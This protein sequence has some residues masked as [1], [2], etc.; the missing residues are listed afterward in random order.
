MPKVLIWS[1]VSGAILF[2]LVIYVVGESFRASHKKAKE[3]I[4][5]KESP[6]RKRTPAVSNPPGDSL[7]MTETAATESA[8]SPAAPVETPAA[9]PVTPPVPAVT[10]IESNEPKKVAVLPA[11]PSQPA[12]PKPESPILTKPEPAKPE[13]EVAALP[14]GSAS[15]YVAPSIFDDD[16]SENGDNIPK[17]VRSKVD[18]LYGPQAVPAMIEFLKHPHA[19]VRERAV[20]SLNYQDTVAPDAQDALLKLMQDRVS[21]I[22][23]T[24]ATA[25]KKHTVKHAPVIEILGAVVVKDPVREVRIAAASTL[26]DFAAADADSAQAVAAVLIPAFQTAREDDMSYL[27]P[28]IGALGDAAAP[29]LPLL[30]KLLKNED[31]APQAAMALAELGQLEPLIPLIENT[32][33]NAYSIKTQI[34]EGFGRQKKLT[35]PMLEVLKTL[36]TDDEEYVRRG[37]ISALR[38]CEPKLAE[39]VP[40]LEKAQSD[41]SSSVREAAAEAFA[42]YEI[43]PDSKVRGLLKQMLTAKPGAWERNTISSSI[44][45]MKG[46]GLNSL[47]A[48]IAEPQLSPEMLEAAIETLAIEYWDSESKDVNNIEQMKALLKDAERPLAVRTACAIVLSNFDIQLPQSEPTLVEAVGSE[49]MSMNLR[50]R[51][52]GKVERSNSKIL[53]LFTDQAIKLE[54]PLPDDAAKELREARNRFH[55]TILGILANNPS[56]DEKKDFKPVLPRFLTAIEK[57]DP[58]VKSTAL[59]YLR[60]VGIGSPE[61]VEAARSMLKHEADGVRRSALSALGG[62]HEHA[63]A[64]I[65]DIRAALKDEDNY[66]AYTAAEALGEFGSAAIEAVPDLLAIMTS[67][68]KNRNSAVPMALAKIA[69]TDAAVQKAMVALLEQKK[70]PDGL[71]AALHQMGTR[72]PG[73]V[74]L[75]LK[76]LPDAERG[77]GQLIVAIL[78]RQEADAKPAL[79]AMLKYAAEADSWNQAANIN[80]ICEMREHAIDA[81]PEIV[82]F[83]GSEDE[84]VQSAAIRGLQLM[85][86]VARGAI[87]DLNKLAAASKSQSVKYAIREAIKRLSA[88]PDDVDGPLIAALTD[89]RSAEAA[90][91]ALPKNRIEALKALAR[92]SANADENIRYRAWGILTLLTKQKSTRQ[93]LMALLDGDDMRSAALATVLLNRLPAGGN[94]AELVQQL[95]PWL[96]NEMTRWNTAR[97]ISQLGE[98]AAKPLAVELTN[99][100]FPENGEHILG[101]LPYRFARKLAVPLRELRGSERPEVSQRAT[102]LLALVAPQ[103]PG[104]LPELLTIL[105]GPDAKL[106]AMAIE[107][108]ARLAHADIDISAAIP[109]LMKV[110]VANPAA[111]LDRTPEESSGAYSAV[112]VV[113]TAGVPVEQLPVLRQMLRT[114]LEAGA[115]AEEP[116]VFNSYGANAIQ[117]LVKLGP[118]AVDALP[119]IKGM[120]L[121]TGDRGYT[122]ALVDLGEPAIVMLSEIVKDKTVSVA[123]RAEFTRVIGRLQD[124]FASA[125][126]TLVDLLR[127][128]ELVVRMAAALSLCQ[129]EGHLEQALPVLKEA[130]KSDDENISSR[131]VQELDQLGDIAAAALVPD[132][133]DLAGRSKDWRQ[134]QVAYVLFKLAPSKPEVQSVIVQSLTSQPNWDQSEFTEKSEVLIPRLIKAV[135]EESDPVRGRAAELLGHFEGKASAAVPVLRELLSD[136]GEAGLA[137]AIAL[138]RIDS[139]AADALP[140]LMTAYDDPMTKYKAAEGLAGLGPKAAVMLPKLIEEIEAGTE[141]GFVY[142]IIGRMGPAAKPAIPLL[143]QNLLDPQRGYHIADALAE[144]AKTSDDIVPELTA[145][146]RRGENPDVIFHAFV[147]MG[148]PAASVVNLLIDDLKQEETRLDALELLGRFGAAAEPALPQLLEYARTGDVEQRKAAIEVMRGIESGA[149]ESVPVLI[150]ALDDKDPQ[151]VI[152]A[153]YGLAGLSKHAGPAMPKIIAGL[154][155][156]LKIRRALLLLCDEMGPAAAD[157]LP[158]IEKLVKSSDE[159][160][161]KLARNAILSVQGKRSRNGLKEY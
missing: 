84:N 18:S 116:E 36:A 29:V 66:T 145:I 144:L 13:A 88:D 60:T 34:A 52:A 105:D 4:A 123:R 138:S 21:R 25:L 124:D 67:D 56:Y 134:S 91:A 112:Q 94:R 120:L 103:E 35:L 20:S 130:L 31:C 16:N 43:N 90:A 140:R 133:V 71:L 5:K 146:W 153:A 141:Q 100:G 7:A 79:P 101:G 136:E 77:D 32:K 151:I 55:Q 125:T 107:S 126:T 87:P 26:R 137:A 1:G 106:R 74:P 102:L 113:Q 9:E 17:E 50:E 73:V 41:S 89:A 10:P 54:Q 128:D 40:L 139:T 11:K 80:V 64:T 82:K 33:S 44:R 61:A 72:I 86:P 78:A 19:G 142:R 48:L 149:A 119:E 30:I 51:A 96:R 99:P 53:A 152:V 83:A 38:T 135:Q 147:K 93:E 129:R 108:I 156:E 63:K 12:E 14:L 95:L 122:S 39:A 127:D 143:M 58:D 75:L 15:K 150:A 65:P 62:L 97:L 118:A 22:R 117:L 109:G 28:A 46:A 57:C 24:A 159:F 115:D 69:P 121:R 59:N 2:M 160:E 157:A 92:I 132:L 49:A 154:E 158:A 70:L 42:A 85:G 110:I 37:A 111:L 3:T 148:A 81:I 161:R 27:A 155:K 6:S 8:A 47:V 114:A 68:E 98:L 131:I 23:T 45:K 76:R 104:I